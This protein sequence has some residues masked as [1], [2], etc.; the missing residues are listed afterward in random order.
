MK[1]DQR[2]YS[3]SEL[4]KKLGIRNK[5]GSADV[6]RKLNELGIKPVD[7]VLHGRG[8]Q[9]LITSEDYEKALKNSITHKHIIQKN[10]DTVT[11]SD[12]FELAGF[13]GDDMNF[14][15]ESIVQ[16]NE[17]LDFLINSWK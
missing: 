12:F 10:N 15:K 11:K 3:A 14:L 13:I 4:F 16:I 17:K 6:L 1:T 2:N 9:F 5:N 8:I 7:Q